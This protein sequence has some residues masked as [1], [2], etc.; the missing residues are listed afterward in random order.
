M[1]SSLGLCRYLNKKG[2]H[3]RVVTP[4]G[5]PE[6]LHWLPGDDEVIE[7]H[8]GHDEADRLIGDA[9][10]VFCLDFNMPDRME[11]LRHKVE[12]SKAAKVLIDHHPDPGDFADIVFSDPTSSSTAQIIYE[13]IEALG[14]EDMVDHEIADCLY[15]GI[16]TD[17]GSFRFSSTS[18]KTHRIAARLLEHGVQ[19][20]E[21]QDRI[22]DNNSLDRMRLL[23]H[24]LSNKLM[25][26]E[27]YHTAYITL[28]MNE[29]E[30]FKVK[31][32]DT[33]GFV[34]KALS[35]QGVRFAVFFKEGEDG[36]KISFRSKGTF[37]AN[38]LARE[39]FGG[40]GHVNAAG[41]FTQLSLQE[42]VDRLLKV[43][44][45]FVSQLRE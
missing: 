38:K 27:E 1:G 39:H 12:S 3:A 2:H 40:G 5:Y 28:D 14:D 17:T 11:G 43:L 24:V 18:P 45:G 36:V 7:Y 6:F 16:M 13:F 8:E 25:V 29:M 33:E 32:G 35:V 10:T 30:R 4:N 15:V 41:G 44:P 26:E 34:N 42:A 31:K 21:V 19:G 9:G 37:P 23:G 20:A 22:F